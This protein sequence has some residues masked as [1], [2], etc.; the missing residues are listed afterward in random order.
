MTTSSWEEARK[1]YL[2]SLRA[3]L[4]KSYAAEVE[5]E[6]NPDRRWLNGFMAAGFHSGL[7]TL[8]ELKLE[9][10]SAHRKIHKSRASDTEVM[11]LER[12]LTKLCANTLTARQS[13]DR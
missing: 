7:V 10:L 11:A 6:S 12:R 9:N 4:K 13:K 1:S 2:T 5:S 8:T 3:R